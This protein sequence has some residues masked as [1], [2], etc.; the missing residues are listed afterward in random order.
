MLVDMAIFSYM[1]MKYK[2]VETPGE[3]DE[4]ENKSNDL[5]LKERK[6]SEQNGN[7]NKSFSDGEQG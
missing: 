3:E 4:E 1:A 7:V 5:P 2:Y 6:P